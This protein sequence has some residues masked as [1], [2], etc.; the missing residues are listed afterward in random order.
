M[1]SGYF[2][3]RSLDDG[4]GEIGPRTVFYT[5][6][7]GAIIN[8]TWY[9]TGEEGSPTV[10]LVHDIGQTRE[11]WEVFAGNLRNKGY[12]VMAMDLRG[13]GESRMNVKDPDIYYDHE[14][15][16]DQ[17]FLDHVIE[18]FH[19]FEGHDEDPPTSLD[20]EDHVKTPCLNWRIDMLATWM[21][22]NSHK[23]FNTQ[24]K[25]LG[26]EFEPDLESMKELLAKAVAMSMIVAL[27]CDRSTQEDA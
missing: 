6:E 14:T 18:L 4:P 26:K 15:M 9:D 27:K 12:N 13:H 20:K 16:E 10:Y 7:D 22:L 23:E 25:D 1:I 24:Y 21:A 17:D 5:S 19:S 2:L 3:Y 8:A 11:V